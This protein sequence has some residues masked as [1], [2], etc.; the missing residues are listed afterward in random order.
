MLQDPPRPRA[1]ERAESPVAAPAVSVVLCVRNGEETLARQLAALRAQDYAGSWE[2]VVVDNASTDATAAVLAGAADGLP[3]RVLEQPRVGLNFA[4]NHAVAAVRAPKVVCCDADD[5]VSPRWLRSMVDALDRHDLVGGALE[6]DRLNPPSA[7]NPSHNQTRAL[8]QSLDRAY[9]VGANLGFRTDVWA[10]VGGF[11][12][13]FTGGCDETDFCLRAQDAGFTIGFEPAAVVHYRLRTGLARVA[14][15]HF[16]Y[17]RGEER[18]VAKRRRLG[19][20]RD[21]ESR[22]RWSWL[23]GD[24]RVHV[25]GTPRMLATGEGRRQ[26]VERSAFLTGRA[27]ELVRP[28]PKR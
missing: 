15:Q 8:P 18:M 6:V 11:D 26:F 1:P 14:R 13:R 16:G 3:I 21:R 22:G 9:A 27:V 2:L 7:R 4:R 28:H 24:A 10:A 19:L 20:D 12:G 5:E 17:G 25:R 23:A